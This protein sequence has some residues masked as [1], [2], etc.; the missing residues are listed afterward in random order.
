[1]C[2]FTCVWGGGFC[3]RVAGHIVSLAKT[4]GFN[5]ALF[6]GGWLHFS[7]SVEEGATYMNE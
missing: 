6:I 1:M 5:Y 7:R 4:G 3:W 2:F